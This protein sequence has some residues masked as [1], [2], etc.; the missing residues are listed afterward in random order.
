MADPHRMMF[1]LKQRMPRAEQAG[2]WQLAAGDAS[3]MI[4]I[5]VTPEDIHVV[6]DNMNARVMTGL[7]TFAAR[8][9]VGL[10]ITQGERPSQE[11]ID[12]ATV[13]ISGAD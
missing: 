5:E 13:V 11:E 10:H 4:L 6:Q 9:G 3:Q 12:A 7:A 1:E 2:R 8:H